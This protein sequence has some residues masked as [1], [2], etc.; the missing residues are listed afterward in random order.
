MNENGGYL[1]QGVYGLNLEEQVLTQ[2]GVQYA[3]RGAQA[4]ST[5][6][7]NA[8][9]MVTPQHPLVSC[10]NTNQ[11][12]FNGH[13]AQRNIDN[14]VDLSNGKVT[15]LNGYIKEEQ[16]YG[17]QRLGGHAPYNTHN[18]VT[19]SVTVGIPDQSHGMLDGSHHLMTGSLTPPDKINGDLM[20]LHNPSPMGLVPLTHPMQAPPSPLPTPSPPMMRHH[21]DVDPRHTGA[22]NNPSPPRENMRKYLRDR[23]DQILVILHAKVAQKSYGNEKRF[24]CPPPCIYLFGNGWKRKKQQMEEDGASEQD[25][26]VCAFMGIGNSDQEM[27]QLNLEGK[28]YCAAKTLYI[29]DSDKR[30]HFMLSV[31]MFHG[32]GQDIG[33]FHS[34]RIKVISKPSKK[35]QS[36]KNA[37]LCIA[38]GTKVA[39]FNRLRSQ[40]VSTR[41][42]HVENG[43]FHASS[44]QWGAFTIHLLDDNEDESEEFTV[45]DGYIHYGSTVKLVCSV[46]GMALPRLIIRKVDKQT[47]LLDADDPVS[48]LHKC[49]FYLKDTERMYLCLSQERI[50][51][52]QATP[53]PKEP[54]KE[55]INDGASWTIISTDKA[56]Y[57]FFE[58]MGPV[59]N[60]LTPVPVVHSLHLNGGGDVAMLELN[61]ENFTPAL[62]VWFGDVEAETMFR[63][64]ESMLCVVPDISAF[65]AGWKWVRQQLHVPVCLVRND[66]VIYATGL[67]FTYTPEP[68]PRQ[69]SR[70]VDR[71]FGRNTTAS[72]DSTSNYNN[73]L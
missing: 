38:S 39:L 3:V 8:G 58:G 43:N 37:D 10:V 13:M 54:N 16:L 20:P 62:K 51:Q 68:G 23:G 49:S 69:H 60:P 50:I 59:K 5:S 53:C 45:R 33:L 7:Q 67:T 9:Y 6:Q 40:T 15:P 28:N 14:P 17:D 66:G 26:Q 57:T 30:K 47:A 42:L 73:Q 32:N 24:F 25:T 34:K 36:L 46:T 31:K 1:S 52:F 4:F 64:D 2:N 72:P 21:G 41:Y 44:T 27:V 71:L 63:S 65:R 18:G 22:Y 55:M 11:R 61:G 35:K 70:E 29:S 48:Q 19:S 12:R 56:E